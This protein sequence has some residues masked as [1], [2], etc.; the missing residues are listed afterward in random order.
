MKW[1][2]GR[3]KPLPAYSAFARNV[4]VMR[5]THRD[6]QKIIL[7]NGHKVTLNLSDVDCDGVQ[8]GMQVIYETCR[9]SK[10]AIYP[11]ITRPRTSASS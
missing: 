2:Y 11:L 5:V 6:E 8:P 3:G 4:D 9:G 10:A 1:N 7:E